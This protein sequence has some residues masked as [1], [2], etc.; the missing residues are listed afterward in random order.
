[1]GALGF[2]KATQLEPKKSTLELVMENFVSTQSY[3]NYEFKNQNLITDEA[4]R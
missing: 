3:K 2:Q 1:M 4:L